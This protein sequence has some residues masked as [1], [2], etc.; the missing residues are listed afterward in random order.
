MIE[1]ND[2]HKKFGK[3]KVL[4]GIH[5]EYHPGKIYGLVGENG[6]GKTTLFNCMTGIYDYTGSITKSKTLKTGY[7]SASNFFYSQITGLEYL[8]F[9]MKAKGLPASTLTIQHLNEIFQL[10]L[11]RYAAEYSTGMKKKLGFM[12]LLLQ[13]N[14]VFILDEPFNGVDLKGC[15]LMKRLIRQ[16]KAKEKTVII[17]SHLI[18]SLRE[19][20]DIIHYLNEGVIYK[21]YHEETTEE[22][23][24]DILC[25]TKKI[26]S[27]SYFQ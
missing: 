1:V 11:D 3:V 25:N 6:A 15:I 16:L 22:I 7:L 17:S 19:I 26:Q 14:D 18:A 13:E 23:E 4:N 8:E 10:P 20:C 27:T 12:A 24:E 9:C 2:L 5:L 21:E